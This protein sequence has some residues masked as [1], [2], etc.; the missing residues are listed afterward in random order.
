MEN[1]LEV[2]KDAPVL[3]MLIAI[4]HRV[5]RRLQ[6]EDDLSY[7][8]G[9]TEWEAAAAAE[10]NGTSQS[11]VQVREYVHHLKHARPLLLISYFYHLNMAL[12]AGGQLIKRLAKRGMNLPKGCGVALF[13]YGTCS[14]R[15][16]IKTSLKAAINQIVL[17]KPERMHLLNESVAVFERNNRL[18][19]SMEVRRGVW[20][21]LCNILRS[22]CVVGTVLLAAVAS[23]MSV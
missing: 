10:L 7:Y 5:S 23:Y 1:A 8:F 19:A 3:N 22:K 6:F 15:R 16:A 13:D 21:M 11:A 14:Q 18:V 17:T 2:H 9:E 4:R 12:L 20:T